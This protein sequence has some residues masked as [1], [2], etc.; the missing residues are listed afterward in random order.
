M[1]Y[2]ILLIPLLAMGCNSV[3]WSVS[4]YAQAGQNDHDPSWAA[5]VSVTFFNTVPAVPAVPTIS[6][7]KPT[8][9]VNVDN[10][11]TTTV[12]QTGGSHTNGGG[13]GHHHD[14]SGSGDE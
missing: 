14:E 12:S 8:T 9:V 5:G 11:N 7:S 2:A 13:H 3:G 1:K 10:S 6:I 4:P